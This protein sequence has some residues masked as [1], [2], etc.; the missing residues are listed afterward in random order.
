MRPH[1]PL[2]AMWRRAK[3]RDQQGGRPGVDGEHLVDGARR[4]H[5]LTSTKAI[6][7]LRCEGVA[8]PAGSVVHQDL[9]G[10]EFAF[11]R[12]EEGRDGRRIGQV[13]LDGRRMA[14]ASAD[15]FHHEIGPGHPGGAV[16]RRKGGVVQ[17]AQAVAP[18]VC[19]QDGGTSCGECLR[20]RRT[21]AVI[22]AGH[23]RNA[24]LS[25]AGPARSCGHACWSA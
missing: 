8:H 15:R 25:G 12:V 21:D 17:A 4:H 3:F 6:G 9:H 1:W 24:A 11:R 16:G 23:E 2:R 5:V 14:A 10:A 22:R 7:R 13:R 18:E 20:R 19:T